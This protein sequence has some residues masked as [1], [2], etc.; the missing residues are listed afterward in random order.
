MGVTI[1]GRSVL[2]TMGFMALVAV[3][4]TFGVSFILLSIS[5]PISVA[6]AI[7]LGLAAPSLDFRVL[8][9]HCGGQFEPDWA[10]TASSEFN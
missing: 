5:V 4:V 9:A 8:G 7:A 10:Q 3:L 6:L 1:G 2:G